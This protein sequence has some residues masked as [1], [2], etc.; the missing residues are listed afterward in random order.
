MPA[1]PE[2]VTKYLW[3]I[4]LKNL[5]QTKH[6]NFIIERVLEYGDQKTLRWLEKNYQKNEIITTLKSSKKISPK[7]GNFF[8]LIYNIP[9]SELECI[10]KPFTQKQ[11]RF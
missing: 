8:A 11:N 5:S 10:R 2:F 1:I 3:D 4:D 9:K 6:K 7:T